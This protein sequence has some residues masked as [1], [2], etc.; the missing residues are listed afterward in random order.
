MLS[1]Q[2]LRKT[3]KARLADAEVL[4]K[5]RRYDGAVYLCGYAVEMRLKARICQTLKWPG[6][7][8]T[9]KEWKGL[10]TF[11]THDLDL[12]LRLSGVESKIKAKHFAEWSIVGKWDPSVRYRPIGKASAQDAQDMMAAV[13]GLLKAL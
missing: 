7:P 11:R 8:E 2:D 5:G 10:I 13:G 12:L 9:K 6:F 4:T 3:A 1:R